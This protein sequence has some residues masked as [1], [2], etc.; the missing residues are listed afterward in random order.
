MLKQF[1][2][3]ITKNSLFGKKDKLLIAISGGVDSVVLAHLL[4]QA[5]YQ[6]DLV[7][8]NFKLR[9]KESE[10]DEN[11]CREL[12][13]KLKVKIFVKSFD[14]KKYC[15][16]HHISTQMAARVLRYEYFKV[17]AE[18]NKAD[19][20]LTA[21]HANDMIETFFINLLRG[22]GINGISGIPE[23][24]E[25]VVRPLLTFSKEEISDFA[26]RNK[27]KFRLDKSNLE[28]KYE[29]NFLRLNVIPQLKR[30]N[31]SFENV[32]LKSIGNIKKDAAIVNEFLNEKQIDL[33]EVKSY[34]FVIDKIKLLK[35]KHIES[36]LHHLLRPYGFNETQEQDILANLN[37]V[38]KKFISGKWILTI[39]RNEL[40]INEINSEKEAEI[41]IKSVA[42]LKKQ[43]FL[44][45][46][47]EKRFK[48]PGMNELYID[49]EML[50]Y[51]LTIRS[52]RAGEKFRPFGMKGYKL[53]S[54]FMKDEKL[55]NFQREH[56]KL[57]V[58]GN[59]EIIWLIGY[60][61]DDRY[62]VS[63]TGTDF[64]KLTFIE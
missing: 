22:T 44:K 38:S 56:L 34:G 60:R 28:D 49:P 52:K 15:E 19:Y 37:D 16:Q 7:H 8:C 57:L 42:E 62:K 4:K 61:S 53:L 64:L 17:L 3:N 45:V 35:Q 32:F 50:L 13:K 55:N 51:P 58:N 33:T 30:I 26:K 25:N 63:K 29:R 59:G 41:I 14:V 11:F 48:I 36:L 24:N 9:G 31:P 18:K 43:K 39:E 23:K 54:D 46:K 5:N 47:S 12:A 6:F 21:H 1:E 2:L 10:A 20:I 40:L 27:I